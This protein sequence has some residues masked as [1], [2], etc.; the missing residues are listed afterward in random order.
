MSSI[1]G[2]LKPVEPVSAKRQRFAGMKTK[3]RLPL[4]AVLLCEAVL[5]G[6][7]KKLVSINL[8]LRLT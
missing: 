6:K 7:G 5:N 8:L 1:L 2:D 4:R 3:P